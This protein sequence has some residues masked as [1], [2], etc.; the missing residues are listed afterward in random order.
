M[1][2]PNWIILHE[3][4]FNILTYK[5]KHLDKIYIVKTYIM[6]MSIPSK[7]S[8]ANC[9]SNLFNTLKTDKST[10]IQPE[11]KNTLYNIFQLT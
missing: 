4:F 7:S 9:L 11:R 6:H 10:E 5:W 1:L 3:N 2:L 8:Q